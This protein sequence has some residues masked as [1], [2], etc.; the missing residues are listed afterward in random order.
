MSN[1]KILAVTW[2]SAFLIPKLSG[3]SYNKSEIKLWHTFYVTM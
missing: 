1:A 2:N 3:F